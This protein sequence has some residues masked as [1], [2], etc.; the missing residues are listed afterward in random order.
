[1]KLKVR[2]H[3]PEPSGVEI[4]WTPMDMMSDP[5]GAV[6]SD[7]PSNFPPAWWWAQYLDDR[8]GGFTRSEGMRISNYVIGDEYDGPQKSKKGKRG[9]V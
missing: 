1:M 2:I 8:M 6:R 5:V 4:V 7:M 3:K 9:Q